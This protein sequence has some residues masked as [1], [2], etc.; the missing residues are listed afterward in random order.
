MKNE[1]IEPETFGLVA[2]SLCQAGRPNAKLRS[3]L[4]ISLLVLL[5]PVVT[6]AQAFSGVT[7]TVTDANGGAV[8]GAWSRSPTRKL[9][10]S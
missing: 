4:V 8:A 5:C 7:G 3:L 2:P 10:E 9:P 6:S 1:P